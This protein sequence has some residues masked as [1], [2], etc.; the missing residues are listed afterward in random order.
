MIE[1][2]LKKVE[3]PNNRTVLIYRC[4]VILSIVVLFFR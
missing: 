2:I 4:V 3:L 1:N